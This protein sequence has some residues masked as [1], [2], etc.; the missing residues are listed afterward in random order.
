MITHSQDDISHQLF[1]LNSLIKLS[2]EINN[3]FT[4][5]LQDGGINS[6]LT[7]RDYKLLIVS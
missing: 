3:L 7:P 4:E 1:L 2:I 5:L 6:Q